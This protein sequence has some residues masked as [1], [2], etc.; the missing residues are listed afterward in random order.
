MT[1]TIETCFCTW[2]KCNGIGGWTTATLLES[3]PADAPGS[4]GGQNGGSTSSAPGGEAGAASGQSDS[5]AGDSSADPAI[6]LFISV[7]I[8]QLLL[9]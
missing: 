4:S 8:A 3:R 7:V 2:D 9:L 6:V 5:S 1:T